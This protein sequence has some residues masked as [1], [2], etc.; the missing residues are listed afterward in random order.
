MLKLVESLAAKAERAKRTTVEYLPLQTSPFHRCA[1]CNS[2]A[3]G[4][5]KG[6]Q[7]YNALDRSLPGGVKETGEVCGNHECRVSIEAKY[8]QPE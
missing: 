3:K 5:P 4:S 2:H 8:S 7:S 1:W 6:W